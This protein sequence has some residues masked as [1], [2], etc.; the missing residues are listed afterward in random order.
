MLAEQSF[1]GNINLTTQ[2]VNVESVDS[3][4]NL[5]DIY[6][7]AANED[8]A[9]T[10][11][12]DEKRRP[13]TS[14]A[15]ASTKQRQ[16]FVR[17][18]S[19]E[20]VNAQLMCSLHRSSPSST[21]WPIKILQI[22]CMNKYQ[23]T[24]SVNYHGFVLLNPH[25]VVLKV[26]FPTSESVV[27]T[28]ETQSLSLVADLLRKSK[29]YFDP[30]IILPYLQVSSK[31]LIDHRAYFLKLC[32]VESATVLSSSC[33]FLTLQLHNSNNNTTASRFTLEILCGPCKA[34]ELS[35]FFSIR[36]RSVEVYHELTSLESKAPSLHPLPLPSRADSKRFTKSGFALPQSPSKQTD[37]G[38]AFFPDNLTSGEWVTSVKSIIRNLEAQHVQLAT[39]ESNANKA[40]ERVYVRILFHLLRLFYIPNL[41]NVSS[42][43][44]AAH[45]SNDSIR[46]RIHGLLDQATAE[47]KT[48]QS[49]GKDLDENEFLIARLSIFLDKT[50]VDFYQ[51]LIFLTPRLFMN[52][53]SSSFQE[54]FFPEQI[55]PFLE[56]FLTVVHLKFQDN[57]KDIA[58]FLSLPINSY[59]SDLAVLKKRRWMK[60]LV[61]K[62]DYLQERFLTL[63]TLFH[64]SIYSIDPTFLLLPTQTI[65]DFIH[66]MYQDHLKGL[67]SLIAALFR[68]GSSVATSG[69]GKGVKSNYRWTVSLNSD[70][71]QV[72]L[73]PENAQK[74]LKMLVD[75]YDSLKQTPIIYSFVPSPAITSS[76]PYLK[77]CKKLLLMIYN[78]WLF[79]GHE[80]YSATHSHY[81]NLSLLMK[82]NIKPDYVVDLSLF[83]A[84][85]NDC[86]RI[87]S[88][89]FPV[90]R[91]MTHKLLV[92][93]PTS[94]LSASLEN[95]IMKS[96]QEESYDIIL[97]Q[98]LLIITR[99]IF[100]PVVQSFLHF[101]EL[102][103]KVSATTLT[104]S[105]PPP[106]RFITTV[107]EQIL[108][109]L[110]K[111]RGWFSD[112]SLYLALIYLCEETII[113][114]YLLFIRDAVA[115]T[116]NGSSTPLHQFTREEVLQFQSDFDYMKSVFEMISVDLPPLK[117]GQEKGELLITW[118]M[119]W[120]VPPL[121]Y[122]EHLVNLLVRSIESFEFNSSLRFLLS[123]TEEKSGNISTSGFNQVISTF[124]EY[125]LLHI[126][127]PLHT[128][129][130]DGEE[131]RYQKENLFTY[132]MNFLDGNYEV[133]Y[134]RTNEF[135]PINIQPRNHHTNFSNSIQQPF[136]P[137][138]EEFP[139]NLKRDLL[140]RMFS[141]HNMHNSSNSTKSS[142]INQPSS[143]GNHETL[144]S[145]PDSLQNPFK[146][147]F[148][149]SNP[150]SNKVQVP[151]SATNH[152]IVL[153]ENRNG[154]NSGKFSSPAL[155]GSATVDNVRQTASEWIQK[156]TFMPKKG[157]ST[158]SS[159]KEYREKAVYDENTLFDVIG[160]EV[161]YDE[162]IVSMEEAKGKSAHVNENINDKAS[163]SNPTSASSKNNQP[164][165]SSL[166]TPV[167]TTRQDSSGK[168]SLFHLFTGNTG[169][170]GASSK[171][172]NHQASTTQK[173]KNPGI[174]LMT[175]NKEEPIYDTAVNR[176]TPHHAP[177]TPSVQQ[178]LHFFDDN[179]TNTPATTVLSSNRGLKSLTLKISQVRLSG[180]HTSSIFSKANPYVYFLIPSLQVKVKTSLLHNASQGDFTD[181]MQISLPANSDV[182]NQTLTVEVYDKEKIRRK[183][184]LGW[185]SFR[186]A[187]YIVT[188]E[189]QSVELPL[190]SPE[191]KSSSASA[192]GKE[193]GKISFSLQ[194]I[195]S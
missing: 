75:Y 108:N 100:M 22:S 185:N 123:L 180:I 179:E 184:L 131:S 112:M 44:T 65:L 96:L 116:S 25:G 154:R 68:E 147:L 145:L 114:R 102:Y 122:F 169:T 93:A 33:L 80:Y 148:S 141:P 175:E 138:G 90:L 157:D 47:V 76:S 140:W 92:A 10:T 139:S 151:L 24:P 174:S 15:P 189:S 120:T 42:D 195:V 31:V 3:T 79:V 94:T 193:F 186:L 58:S 167:R 34:Q 78:A 35:L 50:L 27:A 46:M 142:V 173:S 36:R 110:T 105:N 91:D 4:M 127:L 130:N 194:F 30:H 51:S 161:F 49:N 89:Y 21:W 129:S 87:M 26:N 125:F 187:P 6:H 13:S 162:T 146:G 136:F 77:L 97:E 150:S 17:T 72:S 143:R 61:E 135:C 188:E 144:L 88:D 106:S 115:Q 74:I 66:Q 98:L 41:L 171:H 84:N 183:I 172:N 43:I 82:K 166:Q 52:P 109:Y 9:G 153:G 54:N 45:Y 73:I 190:V 128:E 95:D 107:C 11:K 60:F 133:I 170:G 86:S 56:T 149:T 101:D 118:S 14:G 104:S 32:Q 117:A 57:L 62:N 18:K 156:M 63:L 53:P 158:V 164:A 85:L 176:H 59:T 182:D 5:D 29:E 191:G 38:F 1:L 163:N 8:M 37:G 20:L 2:L 64:P 178:A 124:L 160:L 181:V 83:V 103:F 70:G 132:L 19:V 168:T 121:Q 39:N 192:N 69:Q 159:K 55:K 7:N 23:S 12:R 40:M 67:Q 165:S 177:P 28:A 152:S 81:L 99:L 134:R 126:I 119:E 16:L 155:I 71:F 48:L 111:V 113:N 137:F